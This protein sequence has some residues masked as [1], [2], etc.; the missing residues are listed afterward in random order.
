MERKGK[1]GEE[2]G[3]NGKKGEVRGRKRKEGERKGSMGS[4]GVC[5][6]LNLRSWIRKSSNYTIIIFLFLYI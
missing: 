2:M 1:E 5:L 3:R 6:E 4:Q